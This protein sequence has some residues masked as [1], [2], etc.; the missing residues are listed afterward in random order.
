MNNFILDNKIY[1][2][3]KD[4]SN[5]I[6]T[7]KE[8]QNIVLKGLIELD[9]ICRKNDIPYAL[10]FGTCLGLYNYGGFIPWDDDADVIINY[11]DIVRFINA[12]KTD[13]DKDNFCL[14]C[15][16]IDP[17]YNVLLPTL[18]LKIK[19]TYL[20]EKFKFLPN[21]IKHTDYFFID[22]C[23]FMGSPNN[24]KD[25]IKALQIAKKTIIPYCFLDAILK[26]NPYQ[27][28]RKLKN[29]EKE[30]YEKYKDSDFV[31]QTPLLPFQ[32]FSS[33]QKSFV[34]P[35][36]IIYPFKEYDFMGHKFF[37]F[38]NIK[39]FLI[40]FYGE[41]SLKKKDENGNYFDPFPLNK[42]K[43]SHAKYFSTRK[44]IYKDE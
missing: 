12:C 8:A 35:K 37:S 15:Y 34:F 11:Q 22:I 16:E 1:Y 3:G 39:Q 32:L 40:D 24:D 42:R 28:K 41:N 18:K 17:K 30:Y 26:I 7:T 19:H 9:R 27:I 38:N 6:I 25:Y 4:I 13:L 2:F 20:K 10:A 23:A 14:S 29:Y 44:S 43:C 5:Q 36:N 33:F 31:S 21:K